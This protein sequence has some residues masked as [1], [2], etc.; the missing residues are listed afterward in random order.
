M[1]ATTT[2]ESASACKGVSESCTADTCPSG[3]LCCGSLAVGTGGVSGSTEC[4]TGTEC[5]TGT[6]ALCTTNAMCP[7]GETC[8]PLRL[9]GGGGMGA[10][11]TEV[12]Q[13][14][15]TRPDGGNFPPPKDAGGD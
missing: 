13:K 5:P 1:G 9:G 2:C 8:E 6:D 7:Q 10:G 3:S 14:P 11:G 12:C 4:V 15:V